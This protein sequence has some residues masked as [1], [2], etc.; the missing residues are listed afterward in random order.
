MNSYLIFGE[1]Q[2]TV[3]FIRVCYMHFGS[4]DE[5]NGDSVKLLIITVCHWYIFFL[6]FSE[7]S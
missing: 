7:S 6:Y 1:V 2:C 5:V 3:K 4:T